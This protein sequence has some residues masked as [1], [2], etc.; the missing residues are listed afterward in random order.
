MG[1][2]YRVFGAENLAKKGDF[3]GKIA[4]FGV[5]KG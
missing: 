2:S 4:V 5:K 1:T 3:E